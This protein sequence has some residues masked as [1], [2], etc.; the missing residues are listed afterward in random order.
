MTAAIVICCLVVVLVGVALIIHDHW[1]F[2]GA[3]CL[4][5]LVLLVLC[6]VLL[7]QFSHLN[8]EVARAP[9]PEQL[10]ELAEVKQQLADARQQMDEYQQRWENERKLRWEAEAAVEE[11]EAE[12]APVE[13]PAQEE[14]LPLPVAEKPAAAPP[15]ATA[16]PR[17]RRLTSG[18]PEQ[19]PVCVT[20]EAFDEFIQAAAR[21][22]THGAVNLTLAGLIFFVDANT[23]VLMLDTSWGAQQVRI[24]SGPQT[25]LSGWVPSEWVVK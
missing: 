11:R 19:V 8:A 17:E 10:T 9:S 6:A 18:G 25:G 20:E 21:G 2:G 12:P 24:L 4:V 1:L 15:P 22:D 14:A 13:A 3:T 5:G 7:N 16:N 23:R